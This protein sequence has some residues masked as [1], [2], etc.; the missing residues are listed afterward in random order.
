[1]KK[2]D[3]ICLF[4]L[5]AGLKRNYQGNYHKTRSIYLMASSKIVQSLM[6][7]FTDVP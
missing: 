2:T 3:K 7:L 4:G 5:K 1:M 6:N